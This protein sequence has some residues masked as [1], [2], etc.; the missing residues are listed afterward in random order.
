MHKSTLL[1]AVAGLLIVVLGCDSPSPQ[2]KKSSSAS[3]SAQ[4]AQIDPNHASQPARSN[5]SDPLESLVEKVL[6]YTK[7]RREL[8][9]EKHAAWQIMHGVLAFGGAFQVG[10]GGQVSASGSADP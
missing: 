5:V 6:D 7:N 1:F 4:Q 10:Q 2:K 3:K 9:L 8:N